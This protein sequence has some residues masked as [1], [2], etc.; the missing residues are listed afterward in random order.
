MNS[1]FKY[2]CYNLF[3]HLNAVRTLFRCVLVWLDDLFVFL[4]TLKSR[5]F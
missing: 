2:P 1:D 5:I 3:T 4:Q